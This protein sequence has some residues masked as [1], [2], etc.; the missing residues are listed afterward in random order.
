MHDCRPP[1]QLALQIAHGNIVTDGEVSE[2]NR[3]FSQVGD[4]LW[5]LWELLCSSSPGPLG[6]PRLCA[7]GLSA[8]RGAVPMGSLF[9]TWFLRAP[10]CAVSAASTCTATRAVTPAKV[11]WG[12]FP[13]CSSCNSPL[14]LNYT[15]ASLALRKYSLKFDSWIHPPLP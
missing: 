1:L 12:P 8:L 15:P 14:L 10:F 2:I 7:D 9:Y 6:W 5:E 13:Y 11:F 4:F 3:K